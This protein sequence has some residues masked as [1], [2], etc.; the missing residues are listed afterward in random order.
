M[1]NETKCIGQMDVWSISQDSHVKQPQWCIL[2]L[3]R[4]FSQNTHTNE[5]FSGSS[6]I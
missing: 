6:G 4:N 2:G 1:P 3:E 5:R